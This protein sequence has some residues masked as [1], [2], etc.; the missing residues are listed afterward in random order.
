MFRGID[1]SYSQGAID[2]EKV[3]AAG[4]DFAIIRVGYGSD[5]ESQDDVQAVRNMQECERL[6]IPYG[7]Y[8]YSYALKVEN[9]ISEA[10]HALRM[11]EGFNPVLGIWFDMEDADGY[12]AGKGLNVYNE[13]ELITE[14]CKTFCD[15]IAAAGYK[16]G[17]YAN[18]NYFDNVIIT[19]DIKYPLWLAHWGIDEPSMECLIWQ[20]TSNGSVDGVASERVDM[21]YYYGE[22]PDMQPEEPSEPEAEQA[23]PET[24]TKYNVGDVVSYHTIY[25]ASTSD[26]PL[27]PS[28]TSGVITRVIP[29]RAHPY[30]I[31]GGTGWIDD[32]CIEA[33]K[34]S[35]SEAAAVI[36][37]GDKVKVVNAI[38]YGNGEKFTCYYD[39]YD[40][41]Q[42]DGDRIVIGIGDTVTAAVHVDNLERL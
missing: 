24:G 28:I 16:T 32:D 25:A 42:A 23:D 22:L 37:K 19:D 20:Y 7:V 14:M 40:V 26:E 17:V 31:G 15:K 36:E 18:K 12:K 27:T 34:S 4:I 5:I 33:G 38:Q 35:E 11:I 9:A 21:N 10:E 30:L 39:T 29:G 8:L 3:K 13:R 41:I 2:W 6:G 1:V